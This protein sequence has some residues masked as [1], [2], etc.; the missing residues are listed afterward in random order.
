MNGYVVLLDS[1]GNEASERVHGEI[2]WEFA[3]DKQTLSFHPADGSTITH[4]EG[5]HTGV[6][7][8]CIY[9]NDNQ[10]LASKPIATP[11]PTSYTVHWGKS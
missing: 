10:L 7:K 11:D 3:L 8:V 1:A 4:F 2:G 6:H 5:L 9:S